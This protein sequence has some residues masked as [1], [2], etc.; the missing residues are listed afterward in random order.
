MLFSL[1][2]CSPLLNVCSY[3]LTDLSAKQCVEQW[4]VY[5]PIIERNEM[6]FCMGQI[7]SDKE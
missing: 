2:I 3:L 4:E 5:R 7:E 6:V 1:I